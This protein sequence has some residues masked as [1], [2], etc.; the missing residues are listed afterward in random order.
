MMY[1]A[2]TETLSTLNYRTMSQGRY[3]AESAVNRAAHHL[4][5]QYTPP[6]D[7]TGYDVTALPVTYNGVPV[8]LTSEPGGSSNY[9]DSGAAEAFAAA[10]RGTLDVS[11]AVVSYAARAR[12]LSM[13][14][15]QHAYTG[16]PVTIQK[17][18]ITGIGTI[19]G[20]GS[21]AVEVTAVI[22]RQIVPAYEYAAFAS[23]SGCDAL[24]FAGGGTTDS[25]DSSQP[26]QG[27]PP[28]PPTSASD[29]DVGTNGNLR[30][31]GATTTINGTLSTPRT[32]VGDCTASN[33]T[34]ATI[35]G[36]ATVSGGLVELPQ[37]VEFPTP[38]LPDPMPPANQTVGFSGSSCPSPAS[39]ISG[40]TCAMDGGVFTMQPNAADAPVV[41]GNV[42]V[43]AN[44]VLRLSAGTYIINSLNLNSNSQ[45][46]IESGPV[47]IH[48]AGKTATG[49]DI[50]VPI[51]LTTGVDL[52]TPTY[53][54]SQLQFIY[55][56]TGTLRMR[57]GAE[58]AMLVYAP[59]GKV[60]LAGGADYYGAL[61]AR[62]VEVT[63]SAAIHYDR[64]LR[65]NDQLTIPGQ[66]TLSSFNWRAF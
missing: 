54:A 16:L 48:V 4:L 37:A 32:G 40:G 51:D 23:Y 14:R 15:V 47:T 25:Y 5:H 39:L 56:G 24:W 36:N 26:L 11:D 57:G 10:A 44:K 19:A 8:L 3:G 43:Q 50:S 59:N 2:R 6:T 21:A 62:T 66:Y 52:M 28:R 61:I 58:A 12:L 18:E 55:A 1:V 22:D 31:F 45:I 7:F 64:A 41:L 60:D 53:D 46:I 35:G 33:V 49:T 63:G 13:R 34:A 29:G 20:A 17:W 38:D 9:H 65:R 42:T 27:S 30:E